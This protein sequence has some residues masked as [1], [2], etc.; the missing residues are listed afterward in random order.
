[1]RKHLA[2]AAGLPVWRA[3]FAGA[4]VGIMILALRPSHGAPSFGHVDKLQHAAAFIVLWL[5]AQR[6]G[7]RQSPWLLATGLL[8]FGIAIE[9]AQSF[10]PDR[11]PSIGDIVADGMGIAAGWWLLRRST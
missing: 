11:H 6:A 10:T 4:L 1:V 7:L 9:L 8:V 2:G 5:I 3:L